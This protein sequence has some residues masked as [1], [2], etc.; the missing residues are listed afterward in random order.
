[1]I[2]KY[3]ITN[4]VTAIAASNKRS[5]AICNF[6][7]TLNSFDIVYPFVYNKKV[8]GYFNVTL[9]ITLRYC[10]RSNLRFPLCSLELFT[11]DS[12][13]SRLRVLKSTPIRILQLLERKHAF[14][15]NFVEAIPWPGFLHAIQHS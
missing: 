2:G 5:I 6:L 11:S 7:Q 10:K 8:A 15:G 4:F 13:T 9:S 3:V 14:C 12:M 1:M